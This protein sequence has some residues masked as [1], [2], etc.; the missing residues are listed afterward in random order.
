[1]KGLLNDMKIKLLEH[2]PTLKMDD[3]LSFVHRYRAVQGHIAEHQVKYD[4]PGTSVDSGQN[5]KLSELMDLVKG[6]TIKLCQLEEALSATTMNAIQSEGD[7][8]RQTDRNHPRVCYTC[9]QAGHFTKNCRQRQQG[10]C[11]NTVQ[12]YNCQGFG[13]VAQNWPSSL[14]GQ[15]VDLIVGR[16]STPRLANSNMN[17]PTH[18]FVICNIEGVRVQALVDMGSMKSFI[19]KDIHD[20]I[21]FDCHR[22]INPQNDVNLLQVT[23]SK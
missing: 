20:V 6:M 4:V 2:D 5:D 14:N 17:I 19:N 18:P 9:G 3:M 12:C 8:R 22:E 16:F 1:M 7:I 11:K 21:D 15:A 13:H 10:S 23:H